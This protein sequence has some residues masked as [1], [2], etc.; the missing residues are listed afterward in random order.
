MNLL[1]PVFDDFRQYRLV[2]ALDRTGRN[3][4]MQGMCFFGNVPG[5][6]N[7]GRVVDRRNLNRM[8]IYHSYAISIAGPID[9][10]QLLVGKEEYDPSFLVLPYESF[11]PAQVA[12]HP[13]GDR[14]TK[15][16]E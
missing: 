16:K 13:E 14:C 7:L 3:R 10:R 9:F 5:L 6:E 2:L 4:W 11:Y 12:E 1:R 8:R 15:R